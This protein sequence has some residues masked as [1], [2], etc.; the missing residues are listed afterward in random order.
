MLEDN[1][2]RR[3]VEK[4]NLK[5][6]IFIPLMLFI[7]L[8][9]VFVIIIFGNYCCPNN[10]HVDKEIVTEYNSHSE[11]DIEIQTQENIK[12]ILIDTQ[13]NTWTASNQQ[14]QKVL[15]LSDGNFIVVWQSYLQENSS[16]YSIYG[17]IFYSNG[18]KRGD[19]VYINNSTVLDQTNPNVAAASSGKFMVV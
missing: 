15:T 12:R 5:I 18:A 11:S 7:T 2:V 6:Q 3:N 16:V 9:V 10:I 14:N 8:I 19:E 13:I 4:E 17:Q 1:Q